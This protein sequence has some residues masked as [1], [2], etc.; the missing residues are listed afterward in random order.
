MEASLMNRKNGA[1]NDEAKEWTTY[2]LDWLEAVMCCR[3]LGRTALAVCG[4]IA[5]RYLNSESHDA[6][7]GIDRLVPPS[8]SC[9]SGLREGT[10]VV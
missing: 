3:E 5:L 8:G 1:R 6:W 4:L 2:K 9:D 10:K 7:M